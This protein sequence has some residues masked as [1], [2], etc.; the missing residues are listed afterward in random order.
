MKWKVTLTIK[1]AAS[2]PL[3]QQARHELLQTVHALR[4]KRSAFYGEVE[5]FVESRNP[6]DAALVA[7][8][9]V[10]DAL[11]VVDEASHWTVESIGRTERV[12]SVARS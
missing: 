1:S 5:V 11:D 9:Y 2:S 6:T 3:S 8:K 12:Y 10:Q 7:T 4:V